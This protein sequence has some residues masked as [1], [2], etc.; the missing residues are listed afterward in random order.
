[1]K[2]CLTAHRDDVPVRPHVSDSGCMCLPE[3]ALLGV[4]EADGG[5]LLVGV[6]GAELRALTGKVFKLHAHGHR[7]RV[8]MQGWRHG[9]LD[10]VFCFTEEEEQEQEEEEEG[11]EEQKQEE[12][13]E[14]QKQ[15]EE[16]KDEGRK[17]RTRKKKEKKKKENKKKNRN[18]KRKE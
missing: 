6:G 8:R 1:M 12:E 11:G 15:E 17:T 5:V 14:E 18:M 4:D 2:N 10:G 9:A 7:V 3:V 16:Q 13:G